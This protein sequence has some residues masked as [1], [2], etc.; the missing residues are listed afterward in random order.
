MHKG[1]DVIYFGETESVVVL[2]VLV[3]V[4]ICTAFLRQAPEME[5]FKIF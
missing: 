3:L 4:G 1:D 5:V 2:S